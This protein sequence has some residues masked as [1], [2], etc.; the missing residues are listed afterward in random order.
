MRCEKTILPLATQR[1]HRHS[2]RVSLLSFKRTQKGTM[3]ASQTSGPRTALAPHLSDRGYVNSQGRYKFASEKIPRGRPGS[4]GRLDPT[5]GTS[6]GLR[7]GGVM[8]QP[9]ATQRKHRHSHRVSLLSFKRTQKGTMPTSQISGPRTAL[10]PH[11]SDRG[12]VNSQGRYKFASEKIPRR[13]PG[14]IGRLDPTTG[15]SDG[16][17]AGGVM[18]LYF[19]GYL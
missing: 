10:A 8:R 14:S 17:R 7:A 2:H 18:R 6:D 12:Y 9:L 5:T 1:K 13:R 11:L 15:I 16:L 19:E 3:P 4:I